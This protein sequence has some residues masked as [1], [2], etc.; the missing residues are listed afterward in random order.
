LNTSPL[1][2][3]KNIAINSFLWLCIAFFILG[4]IGKFNDSIFYFILNAFGLAGDWSELATKPWTIFTYSLIHINIWHFISNIILFKFSIE[5][6]ERYFLPKYVQKLFFGGII[7]GGL[8]FLLIPQVIV[9]TKLL[10]LSAGNMS[11]L[12]LLFIHYPNLPLTIFGG[13]TFKLKW[14]IIALIIFQLFAILDH[15]SVS[16]TA[17]IGGVFAAIIG[18][19]T[20][21]NQK[22]RLLFNILEWFKNLF[23]KKSK[24]KVVHRSVPRDD[25]EYNIQKAEEQEEL[26]RILDKINTKGYDKLSKDERS[27][28]FKMKKD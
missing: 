9:P 10:G 14:L 17:H 6:A 20:I 18:S 13:F 8:F 19:F 7:L 3:S 1:H 12:F 25:H 21:I 15:S 23:S 11:I 28:L 26:N 27:F 2:I 24:L 4:F 22:P 5:L 16:W